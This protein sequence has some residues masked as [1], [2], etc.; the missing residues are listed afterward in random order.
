MKILGNQNYAIPFL[1]ADR[2]NLL[3]ILENSKIWKLG[4]IGIMGH[5]NTSKNFQKMFKDF[6]HKN[7]V[8]MV[9]SGVFSKDGCKTDDYKKLFEK[10]E[11]M[12]ADYGVMI[13]VFKDAKATLKS[14]EKALKIYENRTYNFKLVA[15]TQGNTLKEY[16]ECYEDLKRMGFKYIAIGGLLQKRINS[17][18]YVKIKNENFMK[19]IVRKIR[20]KYTADWLFLLGCFHPKRIYFFKAYKIFGAD[21]KYWVFQYSYKEKE[22]R[23][24]Q[25]IKNLYSLIKYLYG[26]TNFCLC[27]CSAAGTSIK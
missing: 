21:S 27:P 26:P 19:E 8:K 10:Y 1:T 6:S 20:E 5:A 18:R 11:Y 3:E 17:V 23:S 14:A 25:I 13:D 22:N 2:I 12:K 4:P 9:D 16:L 15:V 24:I 7:M